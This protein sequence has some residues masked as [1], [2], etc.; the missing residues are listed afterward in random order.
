MI[1][2]RRAAILADEPAAAAGRRRRS[3][4]T[5]GRYRASLPADG[6]G[7]PSKLGGR[8]KMRKLAILIGG[9]VLALAWAAAATA[10]DAVKIGVLMPPRGHSGNAGKSAVAAIEAPAEIINSPHAG[11]SGLPLGAGA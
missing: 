9:S 1:T 4:A 3:I 8:P 11:L 7:P 6:H 5:R 2:A 10:A